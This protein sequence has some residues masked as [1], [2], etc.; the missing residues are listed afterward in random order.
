MEKLQGLKRGR[1]QQ[2]MKFE[3]S[4]YQRKV[5]IKTGFKNGFDA[6]T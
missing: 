1:C 6:F 5:G 3:C 2:R 4:D